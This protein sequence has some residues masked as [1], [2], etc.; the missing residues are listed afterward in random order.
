MGVSMD[1]Y[2]GSS[3]VGQVVGHSDM[4][5]AKP[6]I[7]LNESQT[8]ALAQIETAYERGAR[9]L[10][11]GHAGSGKT[12]LMQSVARVFS[13]RGLSVCM[14]APTHKAV[15]VL[16]R[17]MEQDG[18]EI[19]CC[20]IHSLLSLRPR[21][22]G[23]KQVFERASHAKPVLADVV[24]I[25]E[26]SMPSSDL[27]AHIRDYLKWQFV[28]FV[29]DPAQLPPVNERESEAFSIKSRSHLDTIVRQ[30]AGNPILEAARVIRESQGTGVM[31]WSWTEGVNVNRQGIFRPGVNLKDWM[32]RAFLSD[33]FEADPDF[34]RY[35]CWTNA[36]VHEVNRMVRKWR[37]GTT[38][39]PLMPNEPCM[40]RTPVF[41]RTINEKGQDDVEIVMQ[42]CEEG[43]VIS[44]EASQVTHSFGSGI[45]K[46]SATVPTWHVVLRK[47]NGG[48]VECHMVRDDRAYKRAESELRE[49][50]KETKDWRSFFR[51]KE[52][53]VDLR[54]LYALTVHSSQGSTFKHA[55][56]DVEDISRREVSNILECQQMLYVAVTRPTDTVILGGVE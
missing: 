8:A 1:G 27:M 25:D 32:Q 53:F 20:T 36:R 42:N 16:S 22:I 41:V 28:L 29:G 14:T 24:V 7:I 50:C 19:P 49:W 33:D 34:A 55:I 35:L 10:L 45:G 26:A 56:V 6:R 48:H 30:V 52:D 37:Y 2:S 40:A 51:F 44:I 21:V 5:T 38:R 15:A 47:D 4:P 31:D 54:P 13:D 12:T 17:K 39:T 3:G 11:T 18:I 43:V 23:D 46:W 9:H